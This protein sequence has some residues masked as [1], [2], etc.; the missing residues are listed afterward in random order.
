VDE[1]S[2]V[3]VVEGLAELIGDEAE[4]RGSE[5]ALSALQVKYPMTE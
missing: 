5:Y 2:G 3:E 1:L 4:V